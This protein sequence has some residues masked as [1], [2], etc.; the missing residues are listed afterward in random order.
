M[1][2]SHLCGSG[3]CV[4][5]V[6]GG[7]GAQRACFARHINGLCDCMWVSF[8]PPRR[9]RYHRLRGS[10]SPVLTATATHHSYGSLAWLFEFFLRLTSAH[11]PNDFDA[12]WLKRRAFTQGWYFCSKNRHFA[13][14][15]ISRAP[16]RWK[17][18][19][20][21]DL[22]IFRSILPLTLEVTERTPLILHRSPMKVH[23]QSGGEKLKY[24]LKFYIGVHVT[25]YAHAQWRFSIVSM[26][27]W[28][29]GRN[30]SETIRDRDLGPMDHQ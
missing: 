17:F 13:Y 24:T 12:K 6:P 15:L 27:T 20:F 3:R 30:I 7:V 22:E 16:K 26:S 9:G 1:W 21:L 18:W 28:C 10:A 23:R 14:P 19:K 2:V 25:W 29:L 8:D 5:F 11:P 4:S